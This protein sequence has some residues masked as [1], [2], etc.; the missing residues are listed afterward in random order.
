MCEL[1]RAEGVPAAT[2]R[3]FPERPAHRRP[4]AGGPLHLY[5]V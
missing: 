2:I 4:R 1:R 3:P 5:P